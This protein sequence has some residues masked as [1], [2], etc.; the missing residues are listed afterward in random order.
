MAHLIRT[1]VGPAELD[2][3]QE[4]YT[5]LARAYLTHRAGG[6]EQN[7]NHDFQR[8]TRSVL[9]SEE[10]IQVAEL[11]LEC[12]LITTDI[13]RPVEVFHNLGQMEVLIASIA[14]VRQLEL[15]PLVSAPTQQSKDEDGNEIADLQGEGFVLEAYGGQKCDS[16]QKIFE[17]LCT[18]AQN[19]SPGRRQFLA[20]RRTAWEAFRRM[21][22]NINE[23]VRIQGKTKKARSQFG[24]EKVRVS[25]ELELVGEQDGICVCEAFLITTVPPWTVSRTSGNEN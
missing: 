15:E 3:L 2:R 16:N 1:L 6:D 14:I 17:D 12:D 22:L 19:A 5:V 18:L 7:T 8:L 20:F 23:R 11:R 21:P 24:N 4:A 13:E 25:A 9:A 10:P